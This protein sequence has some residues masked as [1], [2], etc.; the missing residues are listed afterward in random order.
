MFPF[1]TLKLAYLVDQPVVASGLLMSLEIKFTIMLGHISFKSLIIFLYVL[2]LLG[3]VVT[4]C[5]SLIHVFSFLQIVGLR[6]AGSS[7]S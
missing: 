5:L 6:R 4:N 1:Q 7:Q 3:S 2:I